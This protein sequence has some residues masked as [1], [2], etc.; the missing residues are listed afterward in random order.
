MRSVLILLAFISTLLAQPSAASDYARE[1]KW[2]D[3]VVPGLVVG[4][5]IYLKQAN[6]HEFLALYTPGKDTKRAV[7]L[8]HGMGVH[9]D[10]GLIGVLRAALADQGYT[11]LSIQMPVLKNE[12][13][14]SDYLPTFP[15]ARER[16]KL[17][18]NFLKAKGYNRIAIVSHS[19]GSRMAYSY[20]TNN[21][22]PTIKAWVAAGIGG[23]E[24]FRRLH[25]PVLDLYGEHDLPE[26]LAGA[27]ARKG[28]LMGKT[29]SR[30]QLMPGADHFYTGM[31]NELI[32]VVTEY[33]NANFN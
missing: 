9:P 32:K 12:A 17:A 23:K 11:T 27:N 33:L 18:V 13:E 7:V 4:D 22:D 3:E 16:L 31:D 30:Q 19:L 21:P 6:Q 2:A 5:A 15:E 10:W 14:S 24:D 25:L 29:G 20:L 8:V 1:K 28:A 26:V